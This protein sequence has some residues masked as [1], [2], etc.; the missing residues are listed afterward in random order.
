MAQRTKKPASRPVSSA[1]GGAGNRTD[2]ESPGKTAL[3]QES[4]AKSGALSTN[5]AP[6][7]PDLR[8]LIVAWACLSE[9]VRNR[10]LA[11]LGDGLAKR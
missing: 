6:I 7:D 5:S 2:G 1:S 9:A 4:G 8:R 10:I 3:P 11:L